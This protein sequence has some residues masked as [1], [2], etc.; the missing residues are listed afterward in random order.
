MID[1][2]HLKLERNTRTILPGHLDFSSVKLI[3]VGFFLRLGLLA[4]S[5]VWELARLL[6]NEALACDVA[7]GHGPDQPVLVLPDRRLDARVLSLTVTAS[8]TC[9]FKVKGRN[10]HTL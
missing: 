3:E 2:R 5:E 7:I 1:L 9:S 6:C 10:L 4:D 8:V